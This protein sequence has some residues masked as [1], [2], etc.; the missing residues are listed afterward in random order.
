MPT[1]TYTIETRG[2]AHS[3]SDIGTSGSEFAS[4]RALSEQDR[5]AITAIIESKYRIKLAQD[6]AK[7]D[8]K[9]VAEKLGMKASELN[10][11][12]TLAMQERERGNVLVHERALIEVAEQVFLG[13]RG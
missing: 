13:F 12:V 10:R 6:Q 7:E 2:S 5:Q 9:A 11:I 3:I 8:L 1:D 4:F